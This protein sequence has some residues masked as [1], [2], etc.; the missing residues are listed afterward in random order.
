MKI[1]YMNKQGEQVYRELEEGKTWKE[2]KT[3][4]ANLNLIFDRIDDGDGII[5]QTEIDSLNRILKE[6]D[7]NLNK[8]CDKDEI[9]EIAKITKD[10]W[11]NVR[12][13]VNVAEQIY[14]D[15]FAKNSL[16]FPTTGKH[17]E[18]HIEEVT[19]DNVWTVLAVYQDKTDGK[20]SLFSG[21]MGETGL[22]Y[23]KRAEYCKQIMNKLAERYQE[24]GIYIDDI[25]KEFDNELNYQKETW[26]PAN[27]K[28]LDAIVN[29][30]MDRYNHIDQTENYL[31]N[32]KIDHDFKQGNTGDCWLIA[33]IKALANSP[34][35]LKMLNDSV[36]V[37][38]DGSV[39]VTLKGVNKTYTFTKEE[40]NGNTQLSTGD[41]DVRAIEMAFDKYF[42]E[43]REVNGKVDLNGNSM[44]TAY[45]ILTGKDGYVNFSFI[46]LFKD[47][48]ITQEEIDKF[49]DKNHIVCVSSHNGK[50]DINIKA[51]NGSDALLTGNH[52]YAVSRA[53]KNY[54]YLINPW[55]TSTEI[56]VDI[57]TFKEFFNNLTV[58]DL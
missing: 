52:A 26:T 31:P 11:Q 5:S 12:A 48:E 49:N 37:N 58:V 25:L 39:T 51:A 22:K 57:Q 9:E 34:K 38:K 44:I 1:F 23:D 10:E 35:G 4:N 56:K 20:E 50:K 28:R 18:K 27:A 54:V 24:R 40:I 32:G 53:D 16:G 33:S 8:I 13:K 6:N 14:N 19:A 17:I 7:D 29:K 46:N 42:T 45:N 47:R 2:S 43:E 30:L 3:S 21:I 36:K 41:L 15:I 55:D